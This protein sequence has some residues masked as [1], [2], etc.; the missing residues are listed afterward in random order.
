MGIP[1]PT[2][3][4]GTGATRNLRKAVVFVVVLAL[5][6]RLADPN[7]VGGDP[8][9]FAIPWALAALL[10]IFCLGLWAYHATSEGGKVVGDFKADALAGVCA[11]TA[12]YLAVYVS[13]RLW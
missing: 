2:E 9:R 1:S 10:P 13:L 11:A 3:T 4:A 6:W 8:V 5:E 7:A 12:V